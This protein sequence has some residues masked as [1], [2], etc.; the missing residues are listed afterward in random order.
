MQY[1]FFIFSILPIIIH[2]VF[3]VNFLN[4]NFNGMFYDLLKHKI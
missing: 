1:I 2:D 4:I 3:L